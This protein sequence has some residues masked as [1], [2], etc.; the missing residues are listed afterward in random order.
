MILIVA[1]DD[2]NGML[3][4][5]R[6][7]SQDRVLRDKILFM[8]QGKNLWMNAYSHKQ[9]VEGAGGQI[10]EDEEFLDKAGIG[11]YCFVENQHVAPYINKIEKVVLCKWNRIY[12]GDFHLDLSLS[13]NPW[14]L[15]S[16][17]EF[18]GNSHEKITVEVYEKC[19]R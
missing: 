2:K 13:E 9:F 4:N 11:D 17:E 18:S 19:V 15:R 16:V 12:P 10:T 6:R 3:F 7:Q 8:T 14:R 5:H 1:V